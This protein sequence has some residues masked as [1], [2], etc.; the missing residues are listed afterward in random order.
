[1]SKT[2]FQFFI[3]LAMLLVAHASSAQKEAEFPGIRA[4]MT[5]QEYQ[6]TGLA[7][8]TDAEIDAL[9]D[10]LVRYTII[11]A[12][13]LKTR[14]AQTES[15]KALEK[16]GIRSQILG[17]FK[18]WSGKTTFKLKNGQTWRQRNPNRY[19]YSAQ[20]PEVEIKKNSFGFY[21]LTIIET[22]KTVGVKRLK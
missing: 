9:N 17:E 22:G 15:V 18:G 21:E 10:W 13:Y 14:Y 3:T 11:D 2:R 16:T 12:A 6:Q 5:A 4:V 1:M 19:F 7:K 20:D 8:L